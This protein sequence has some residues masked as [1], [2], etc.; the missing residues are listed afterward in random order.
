MKFI[1]QVQDHSSKPVAR[2]QPDH[3]ARRWQ[4]H[5]MHRWTP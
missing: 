2:L 4:D 5:P 1:Q 3:L